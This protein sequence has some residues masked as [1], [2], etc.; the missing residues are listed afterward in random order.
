[1]QILYGVDRKKSN[2]NEEKGEKRYEN[3]EKGIEGIACDSDY[4]G[5]GVFYLH[6]V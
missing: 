6:G 5:R 4:N 3:A 1:M 2:E